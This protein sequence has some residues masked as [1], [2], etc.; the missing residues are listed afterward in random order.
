M[1]HKILCFIILSVVGVFASCNEEV[2]KS[3]TQSVTIDIIPF[4]NLAE[5]DIDY[6]TVA[7]KKIITNVEVKQKEKLPKQA[8][9]AIRNR[10]RADTLIGY[11]SKKTPLQH[12]SVGL[13]TK[14]ISHTKG[15][16]KDYGIMGLG[17]RPGNACVV[18]SFRLAKEN[19]REQF[20]KV[21]IHELGHTAG[22]PHCPEK[23]C[24]MRD[25]EGK[26]H[27]NEEVDFCINCKAFLIAKGWNLK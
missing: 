12:V 9:Y 1:S 13:T 3:P 17:F 20:F 23:T 19:K 6:I 26:N 8:Y 4:E 21:C 11:L 5:D 15:S 22:L 24:F 10:Y 18:S 2:S 14:D 27:T 7:L 16:I 25:A